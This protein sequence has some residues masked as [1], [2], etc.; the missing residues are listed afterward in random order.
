MWVRDGGKLIKTV[1]LWVGGL[2]VLGL[3][4]ERSVV[5]EEDEVF[6]AEISEGWLQL[7]VMLWM[8]YGPASKLLSKA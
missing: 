3:W 6:V 8:K 2:L 1:D 4:R 5:D 7:P